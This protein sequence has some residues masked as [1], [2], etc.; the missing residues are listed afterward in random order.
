[1]A[2]D[3]DRSAPPSL[4]DREL[5]ARRLTRRR[6][7]EPDFV[8][9]LVADDL[10][11]RLAAITRRIERAVVLGPS[12]AMLPAT[13]E[14]AEGDFEFARIAT[15]ETSP[16]A[17]PAE[18]HSVVLPETDYD[19]VVSLLDLQIVDDV[20]GHLSMLRRHMRADG[21]FIAAVLGGNS[22]TELRR[23]WLQAE[24]NLRGGAEPRVA[25]MI[26]VRDAGG[27]LQRAGFALPVTDVETH[28]VRYAN[29]MALMTELKALGAGNPLKARGTT[30]VTRRLLLAAADRYKAI[31]GEPE[32]RVR[33]TLEIVWMSGWVPDSSQ[34]KPL[35]PG[36][37]RT[38]LTDALKDRSGRGRS[39][40]R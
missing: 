15:L 38:R 23:A 7:D 33:A 26:D 39:R 16:F 37:A 2:P 21:L 4:F 35:A 34:Q 10:S 6:T 24:A 9:R 20:P 8:T 14:T 3:P 18:P 12:I 27:L 17:N 28:V 1:M 29:P 40:I 11:E 31:A 25:P 5:V 30:L 22:L 19:L 36:S 32:G 13:G